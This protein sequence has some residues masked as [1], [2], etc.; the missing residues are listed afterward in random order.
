MLPTNTR[1]DGY[2]TALDEVLKV[3]DST[4]AAVMGS[5]FKV[6]NNC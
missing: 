2:I 6:K 5:K 4:R 1:E 3:T